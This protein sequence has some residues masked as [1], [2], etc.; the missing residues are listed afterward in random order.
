MEIQAEVLFVLQDFTIYEHFVYG[1]NAC[2]SADF[3]FSHSKPFH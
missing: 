3:F 2:A 1:F